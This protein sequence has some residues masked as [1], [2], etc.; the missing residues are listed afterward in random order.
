MFRNLLLLFCII[1]INAPAQPKINGFG[2][3]VI[4]ETVIKDLKRTVYGDDYRSLDED[5]KDTNLVGGE[6]YYNELDICVKLSFF[7][8][9]LYMI[10]VGDYP[11][12][13]GKFYLDKRDQKTDNGDFF[14]A[15]VM[16]FGGGRLSV[17]GKDIS[18]KCRY[19]DK[20]SK[21][22]NYDS[23]RT[24]QNGPIRAKMESK[25][26]NFYAND[27]CQ[28]SY[29]RTLEIKDLA[30]IERIEK[31]LKEK[32]LSEQNSHNNKTKQL[33]KKL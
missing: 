23:I 32:V 9:T 18:C 11:C 24:W 3:L 6:G 20:P 22:H 2:E 15:F 13:T 4:N 31:Y 10:E 28:S 27:G 29:D 7:R 1:T 8:D 19:C 33:S 14:K 17:T 5:V 16:K 25:L 26:V 30:T 12:T 21:Y